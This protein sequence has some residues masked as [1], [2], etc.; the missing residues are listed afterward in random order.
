MIT[1]NPQQQAIVTTARSYLGS[2][3]RHQGRTPEGI[4]CIGL[5]IEVAKKVMGWTFDIIDYPRQASDETMLNLCGQYFSSVESTDLRPGDIL[6][7]GFDN[8]RHAAIVGD[9]PA[10]GEVS[11]IHAYAISRKVIE[12]RLDSLWM[13]RVIGCFRFP[14]KPEGVV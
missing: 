3:W 14:P 8:Q 4:D 12:H 9:Y 6:V 11:M 2:P 1:M 5:V 7:M 10:E 13:G